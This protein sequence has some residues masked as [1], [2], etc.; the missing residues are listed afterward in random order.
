[1]KD[2]TDIW[3]HRYME[4]AW[5]IG[6]WSKDPST[7]VGCVAIGDDG[8]VLSQGY[9]GFP[10][11]FDD[12]IELY[13]DREEKYKYIV[14]AEMNCIYHATLNGIS[15]KGSTFFVS[16]LNVCHEC[17]KAIVQTGVKKVITKPKKL[18][19]LK[20]QESFKTAKEILKQGGVEY[21]I[22]HNKSNN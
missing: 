20:W 22:L 1:M 15:L 18:Y 2:I 16:G 13:L 6:T 12:D 21:E 8:Q 9:N 3:K 10:R 17:A 14:H 19:K 11:K 5:H 4:L 7:Q